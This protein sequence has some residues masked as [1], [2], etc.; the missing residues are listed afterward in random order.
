M[1]TTLAKG[2]AAG[3]L[4]GA[5]SVGV[6]Q[7]AAAAD[8]ATLEAYGAA[9]TGPGVTL[10]KTPHA[11][12]G[13]PSDSGAA[14]LLAPLLTTATADAFVVAGPTGAEQASAQVT[15][16]AMT[17]PGAVFSA[18]SIQTNCLALPGSAPIA[19]VQTVAATLLPPVVIGANP[20]PNSVFGIPGVVQVIA[21]EQI[22]NP[23]GSLTTN[24]LHFTFP[25]GTEVILASATCGPAVLPVAMVGTGGALATGGAAALG[26]AVF[27]IRR[28]LRAGS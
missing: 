10:P 18:T 25:D 5:V 21:N 23:N 19:F 12:V 22:T 3:A 27:L 17:F 11:T 16:A 2:L 6:S 4:L 28:R 20:A 24:G 26:T 7:T 13:N 15:A 1:F 8:P 14:I 9:V